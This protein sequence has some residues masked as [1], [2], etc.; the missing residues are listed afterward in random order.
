MNKKAFLLTILLLN[1]FNS[2]FADIYKWT[3]EQGSVHA[4]DDISQAPPEIQDKYK[5]KDTK[6]QPEPYVSRI[7]IRPPTD[8]YRQVIEYW[9]DPQTN[10]S[11]KL[12]LNSNQI[13]KDRQR[14]IEEKK[15]VEAAKT[16]AGIFF[17]A[18]ILSGIIYFVLWLW[19]FFDILKNQFAGNDKLIWWL[20]IT[21]IPILGLIAY[22]TIGKNQKIKDEDMD[23]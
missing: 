18:I 9:K 15:K 3:D 21:M 4:T 13:N 14:I 22:A 16:A 17:L 1:P 19:A 10:I 20:T 6:S 8:Y 7:P 12:P 5:S 11:Y 23:Y 2:V